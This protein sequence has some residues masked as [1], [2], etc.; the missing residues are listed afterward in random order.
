MIWNST[1]PPRD[2]S[3]ILGEFDGD[4]LAVFWNGTRWVPEDGIIEVSID[5]RSD[6]TC[7]VMIDR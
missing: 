7:W 5:L 2:G 3:K 1:P 4:L 6:P